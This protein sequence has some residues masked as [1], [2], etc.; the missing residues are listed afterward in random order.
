MSKFWFG[1]IIFFAAF[2]IGL[3]LQHRPPKNVTHTRQISRPEISA[4]VTTPPDPN[5]FI[6]KLQSP[7]PPSHQALDTAARAAATAAQRAANI[8]SGN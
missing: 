3:T 1:A 7:E 4:V 2:A 6:R 5:P 8:A